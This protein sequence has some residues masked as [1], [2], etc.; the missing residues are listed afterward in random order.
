MR[1]AKKIAARIM[2]GREQLGGTLNLK[3]A[4][5]GQAGSKESVIPVARCPRSITCSV[6][7]IC[8]SPGE[9]MGIDSSFEVA[10]P[11]AQLAAAPRAATR[12]RYIRVRPR[13]S[14]R[15]DR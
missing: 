12:A 9:V 2:A 10:S 11:R 13:E 1:W 4:S 7:E 6:R 5:F 14:E 15:P 8:G 3:S